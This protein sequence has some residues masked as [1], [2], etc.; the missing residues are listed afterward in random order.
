M[1]TICVW[2]RFTQRHPLV[3]MTFLTLPF[4]ACVLGGYALYDIVYDKAIPGALAGAIIALYLAAT[5][6]AGLTTPLRVASPG[7]V[8][9]F[10]AA[11]LLWAD[12]PVGNLRRSDL[13]LRMGGGG[14]VHAAAVFHYLVGRLH[15]MESVSPEKGIA[16]VPP[17]DTGAFSREGQ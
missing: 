2:Q 9:G 3:V 7:P 12:D 15:W 14:I 11:A 5:F 13:R 17:L 8:V 6:I 1:K 10:A 4:A 16:P